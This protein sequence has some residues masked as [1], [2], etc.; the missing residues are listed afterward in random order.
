MKRERMV[1]DVL[2]EAVLETLEN[3]PWRR[4]NAG[5]MWRKMAGLSK[6]WTLRGADLWHLSAAK[7]VREH[8]P[9]VKL[10]TFD[11]RL[12]TA[13]QVEEIGL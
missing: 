5:P 10:L 7:S 11:T 1:A 8:L 9:E 2:V 13:A 3:G 6:R 4:L 12:R